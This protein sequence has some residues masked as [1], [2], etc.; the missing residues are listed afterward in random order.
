MKELTKY[1][2]VGLG[3]FL[4]ANARYLIDGWVHQKLGGSFPYGTL[5]INSSGSFVLGLF[6][7]LALK[8]I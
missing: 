1:L 5:V 8:L 7:T 6:A 2:V 4:G 3:G